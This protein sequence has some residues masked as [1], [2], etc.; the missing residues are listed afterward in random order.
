[1]NTNL[2]VEDITYLVTEF[3]EI[4][5]ELDLEDMQVVP[6]EQM[7]GE[8]YEEYIIDD[9][10]LKKMIINIFYEEA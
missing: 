9:E 3:L 1:M 5:P 10:A 2:T 8:R 6:G 4:S 7:K